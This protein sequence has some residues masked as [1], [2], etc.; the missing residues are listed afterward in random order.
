[1]TPPRSAIDAAVVASRSSLCRSKRGVC[2]WSNDFILATGFN[3]QP[4]RLVC[5]QTEK[6]KSS[7]RLT[8]VH[9]E[10]S[11]LLRCCFPYKLKGAQLLHVKT[12]EGLPVP[13]G[14]PSCLECSKLCLEAGIATVWL[15]HERG[16]QA[17]PADVFH[18]LTLAHCGIE[19]G[20]EAAR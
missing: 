19:V 7:C 14:G 16:W 1:M 13:S 6:C 5:D 20:S 10:Q 9:A 12:V 15:L 4:G 11:A 3:H 18:R 17:Y 2:I 8:A